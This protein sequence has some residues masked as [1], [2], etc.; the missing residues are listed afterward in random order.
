MDEQFSSGRR[1]IRIIPPDLIVR[2][3]AAVLGM[4]VLFLLGATLKIFKEYR[5]VGSGVTATN[6]ITVSGQGEVFAVPDRATFTVTVREEAVE[7]ADA[8]DKAT[9]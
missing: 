9:E 1:E 3:G 5:Y 4:L 7:V 6:T 2:V 8:Q